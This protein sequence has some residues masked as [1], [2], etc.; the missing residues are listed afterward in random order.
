[1]MEKIRILYTIPNFDTAGSGKVVYDLIR[2]LDKDTFEVFLMCNHSKGPLFDAIEEL[3]VHITIQQV[4]FPL[5]PYFSLFKRIR[6]YKEFVRKNKIDVVHS[7]HWSSDWTEALATRLAGSKFVFTK[8]AMSWGNIHWKIRSF[9]ASYI[10]TIN[11]EMI[12]FFPWKKQLSLIPLGLDTH[13]YAPQPNRQVGSKRVFRIITV[14]N[15]VP[16]KGIEFLIQALH[17]L[18]NQNIVLDIIGDT[19]DSYV[20]DLELLVKTLSLENQVTF[21]GK[22]ADVRNFF[23]DADL[24]AIPTR[25]MGR[26]E[27]MPMALVEAMSMGIPVIGSNISGINYVLKD[28]PQL[29]FEPDNFEAIA[30]K[31]QEMYQMDPIDRMSLGTSLRNYV[32]EHFSM[33]SFISAHEA[34]YSKL[35]SQ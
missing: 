13:Y 31:I 34:L 10:I 16:V 33:D 3:D 14:A 1:M 21:K 35:K 26:K 11:H 4:S 28:F 20:R 27:G 29:I 19:R 24:Y 22:H 12:Q 9:L 15:L 17:Y 30:D 23:A 2:N 7:W 5:A 8:K 6:P 25:N 32:I 18:N